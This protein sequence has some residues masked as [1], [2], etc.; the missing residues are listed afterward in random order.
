MRSVSRS[1]NDGSTPNAVFTAA[2]R[3]DLDRS[4]ARCEAPGVGSQARPARARSR[5]GRPRHDDRRRHLHDDRPGREDGRA[6]DHPRVRLRGDRVVLRGA[7]LRRTRRDGA[8]RR[9]RVHVRVRD[10]RSTDG[11]DHRL[12][13]RLRIRA[14][15]RTRRA[16]VLFGIAGRAAEFRIDVTGLGA[17]V[18]PRHSRA[19]VRL[20]AMG[21]AAFAIRYRR[22]GV[23]TAALDAAR[24]RHPRDGD[25]EQHLRRAQDRSAGGL[26]DR[27]TLALPSAES[28]A[29]RAARLGQARAVQR[30]R[31]PGRDPG[32]GARLLLL[33]RIRYGDDDRRR[34][35]HPATRH[36]ARRHRRARHRNG[37]LLRRRGRP[38]R[39]RA[40]APG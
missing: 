4:D 18:E 10:A 35:P 40:V 27:R 7:L 22:C 24:R 28:H 6:R 19:V 34:M 26:R 17:N 23:R 38:R 21:S 30:R 37:R 32:G 25:D 12:R 29:V 20:L 36:P 13:A 5:R 33:H 16:A 11:V 3:H 39:H 9:K 14:Q 31:R 15:R 2:H 1:A 8:D